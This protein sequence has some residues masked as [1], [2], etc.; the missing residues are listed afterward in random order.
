LIFLADLIN[1]DPYYT[2]YECNEN[3]GTIFACCTMEEYTGRL[4]GIESSELL[5]D[6]GIRGSTVFEDL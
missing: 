2:Q 3:A 4:V 6:N 1:R 5:E